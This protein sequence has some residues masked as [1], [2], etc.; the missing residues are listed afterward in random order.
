MS[1]FNKYLEINTSSRLRERRKNHL[2]ELK[3]HC[4]FYGTDNV[5]GWFYV[6][7]KLIVHFLNEHQPFLAVRKSTRISKEALSQRYIW[8]P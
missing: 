1:V 3:F 6:R 7:K 4:N 8:K 5:K 2:Q